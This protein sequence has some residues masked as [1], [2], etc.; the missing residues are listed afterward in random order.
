MTSARARIFAHE[1]VKTQERMIK[2]YRVKV[3]RMIRWGAGM[4]LP[5]GSFCIIVGLAIYH[6]FI[7]PVAC[8]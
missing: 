7:M 2:A 6:F 1:R 3:K 8:R 4:Y 5:F